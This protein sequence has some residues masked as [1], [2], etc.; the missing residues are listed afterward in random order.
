MA[1]SSFAV[2]PASFWTS[3]VRPASVFSVG[4]L[5][6]VPPRLLAQPASTASITSVSAGARLLGH[7][8][9][10]L[11]AVLGAV[12][13]ACSA[14]RIGAVVQL[15]DGEACLGRIHRE[16]LLLARQLGDR[17]L[18]YLALLLFAERRDARNHHF[19]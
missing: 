9:G 8:V 17:D 12:R 13:R 11:R 3:T 15:R 10:L 1:C 16:A 2:T 4:S 5:S 19:Q 14:A 6:G 7:M 18:L